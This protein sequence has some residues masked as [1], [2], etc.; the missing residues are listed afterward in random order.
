M[1]NTTMKQG[2]YRIINKLTG[3]IY[4]GS[5]HDFEERKYQH[6]NLLKR[7]KHPAKY[8]QHSFNKHGIENFLFEII[9][10]VDKVESLLNREQFYLDSLKPYNS[11]IGYNTLKI[12]GTTLGYKHSE[13]AKKKIAITKKGELHPMFGKKHTTVSK[14]SISDS[15]VKSIIQYSKKFEF[16]KKWKSAIE[17]EQQLGLPV[18]ANSHISHCCNNKRKTAYGFSWKFAVDLD[19]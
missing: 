18:K 8:L 16:I 14:Q 7:G 19:I 6:F 10:T 2:I 11:K 9:E 5:T 1:K 12:A 15:K 4:I 13:E 17:A 3:K